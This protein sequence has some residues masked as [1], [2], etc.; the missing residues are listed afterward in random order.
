MRLRYICVPDLL[1]LTHLYVTDIT[2]YSASAV[3]PLRQGQ[4]K[5]FAYDTQ[6]IVDTLPAMGPLPGT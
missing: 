1:M 6:A 2:V 4:W 3:N 5:K